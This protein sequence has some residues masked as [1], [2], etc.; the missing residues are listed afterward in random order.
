[1]PSFGTKSL[2]LLEK[3]HPK[4]KAVLMEA[5]KDTPQDFSIICTYR[6]KA[7][8]EAAFRAGNTKV[9]F[10]NS[11]HNQSP[12][13]AVD[14]LPYPFKGW[15]DK[16]IHKELRAAALHVIKVGDKMGISLRHG[17]DWDRDGQ[18][19]DEKFVDSP[20]IELHPWRSFVK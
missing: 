11:P 5:I 7:D 14:I 15:N 17:A 4:L 19:N 12:A 1:M 2:L 18:T 8:Q 16:G 13:C 20:H 10:P 9:H 6:G 3:A